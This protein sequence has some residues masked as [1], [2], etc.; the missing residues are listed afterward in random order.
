VY[1]KGAKGTE[2]ERISAVS[3]RSLLPSLSPDTGDEEM[4][5]VEEEQ[6]QSPTQSQNDQ[7]DSDDPF[8]SQPRRKSTTSKFKSRQQEPEPDDE[9][10]EAGLEGRK[11]HIPDNLLSVLLQQ[12]FKQE[13]TRMS[14]P[15]IV[16][17]G[18]YIDTFVREGLAR[19]AWASDDPFGGVGRGNGGM[20]E[21][22]DLER[23]APQLLMD[24]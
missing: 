17:V 2:K 22:E 7:L 6:E 16:A 20:L 24:F 12:F 5:G 8:S 15:A 13:G 9:S 23:L 4:E 1:R 11:E 21:V 10:E 19:A 3:A 18:K 14:K